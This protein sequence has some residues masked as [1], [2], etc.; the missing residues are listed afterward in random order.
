MCFVEQS[1][2]HSSISVAV[3][4]STYILN[5]LAQ[6][7]Q[8]LAN[9]LAGMGSDR[10]KHNHNASPVGDIGGPSLQTPLDPKQVNLETATQV[11]PLVTVA[12]LMAHVCVYEYVSVRCVCVCVSVLTTLVQIQALTERAVGAEGREYQLKVDY[13]ILD[14]KVERLRQKA[15]AKIRDARKQK[16][17]AQA[18]WSPRL[19]AFEQQVLSSIGT[20]YNFSNL[21]E[22]AHPP[23]SDYSHVYRSG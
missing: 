12:L 1:F 10:P 11:Q 15:L 5:L 14:E 7:V 21:H 20:G 16:A 6:R 2:I 19:A 22:L 23:H 18:T 3:T 4:V 9:I 8:E 13:A 17:A